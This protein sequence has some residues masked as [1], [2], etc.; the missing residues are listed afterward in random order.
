MK[1]NN[2]PYKQN[3]YKILRLDPHSSTE[4]IRKAINLKLRKVQADLNN[5]DKNISKKA[6]EDM[7]ILLEARK[8]L[9]DSE[10][11]KEYDRKI[12]KLGLQELKGPKK[13]RGIVLEKPL[14]SYSIALLLDTSGSMSGEKIEDAKEALVSFLQTV[15]L[16]ENEVA[17]VTVGEQVTW[18]S[19]LTQNNS[20]LEKEINALEA[21]GGTPIMQAIKAAHE[22]VLKK[23]K[24]KPVMVFATDGMPTDSSEEEILEYATPIKR[25]GT[26][27]ITIG[28]GEDVNEEFLKRLASSP[29]DYH[30][31]KASFEL[32]EIYK[33]VVSGLVI[34]KG[35]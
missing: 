33:K 31:A 4:E 16:A 30:F 2:I 11:R 8:I 27:I 28:I 5:P 35:T 7:K 17:L 24:A 9:L 14:L 26:R 32:K 29:E 25:G 1:S 15:N 3:Y 19:G 13:Q 34:R 22:E 18:M 12:K 6:D 10:K 21:G 20:Y 23:G